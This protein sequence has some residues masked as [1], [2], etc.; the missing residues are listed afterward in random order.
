MLLTKLGRPPAPAAANLLRGWGALA[1][2]ATGEIGRD[3]RGL[4]AP[5]GQ[6]GRRGTVAG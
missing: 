3:R 4:H 5:S 1:P 6:A 2:P